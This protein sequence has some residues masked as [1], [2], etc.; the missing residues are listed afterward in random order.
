[1]LGRSHRDV[2]EKRYRVAHAHKG[3]KSVRLG[4]LPRSDL[5]W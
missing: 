2:G 3:G 1:M 5:A 4:Q